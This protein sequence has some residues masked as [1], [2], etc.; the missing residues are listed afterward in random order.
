MTLLWMNI[1]FWLMVLATSALQIV[2]TVPSKVTNLVILNG[3]DQ[4]RPISLQL[5]TFPVLHDSSREERQ[6]KYSIDLIKDASQNLSQGV[7]LAASYGSH[8]ILSFWATQKLPVLAENIIKG[9]EMGKI[10]KF[11]RGDPPISCG[12]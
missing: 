11:S 4:K 5:L 9:G 2:L 12:W 7:A 3:G 8:D 1:L 10:R 6:R